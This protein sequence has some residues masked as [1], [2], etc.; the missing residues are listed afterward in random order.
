MILLNHA[1]NFSDVLW[2]LMT[3][4]ENTCIFSYFT[5]TSH[6]SAGLAEKKILKICKGDNKLF[7]KYF[8]S[9]LKWKEYMHAMYKGETYTL[10]RDGWLDECKY[11]DY[12]MELKLEQISI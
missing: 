8:S 3:K 6:F 5:R 12:V 1:V 7:F 9:P 11:C 2:V 10:W 4:D